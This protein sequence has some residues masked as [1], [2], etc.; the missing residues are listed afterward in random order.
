[1]S[2]GPLKDDK[3]ARGNKKMTGLQEEGGLDSNLQALIHVDESEDVSLPAL[4]P[5]N[6]KPLPIV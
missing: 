2:F 3:F 6:Q 5:A 1:M 4:S